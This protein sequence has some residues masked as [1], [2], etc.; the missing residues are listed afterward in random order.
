M[1][2][3]IYAQASLKGDKKEEEQS[4]LFIK[5]ILKP[6]VV[7]PEFRILSL[8]IETGKDNSLYSIACHFWGNIPEKKIVFM[9]GKGGTAD[10]A[11][12]EILFNNS[13]EELLKVFIK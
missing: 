6:V 1:E 5:P 11:E 2:R 7:E 13:E 12:Q 10:K 4:R 3:Y 9:R 8:D